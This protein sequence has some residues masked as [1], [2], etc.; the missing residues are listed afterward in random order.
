VSREILTEVDYLRPFLSPR[1]QRQIS[2]TRVAVAAAAVITL[3]FM[4]IMQQMRPQTP[5]APTDSVMA[6]GSSAAD[7]VRSIASTVD[8]LRTPATRP[9]AVGRPL[10]WDGPLWA[11]SPTTLSMG[12]TSRYEG[13]SNWSVD[14]KISPSRAGAPLLDYRS[15]G[16]RLRLAQ[17]GWREEPMALA[18]P[19]GGLIELARSS[20]M[21]SRIQ[22]ERA[23]LDLN[24]DPPL[25]WKSEFERK[26]GR[27]E[28]ANSNVNHK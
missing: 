11:E 18:L 28:G 7:S 12:D 19:S 13:G 27:S 1:R 14:L 4:G 2:A 24:C 23:T 6:S 8:D 10:R 5:P 22:Q 26:F 16:E 9:A 17:T 20:S 21:V 25:G 3:S 15:S